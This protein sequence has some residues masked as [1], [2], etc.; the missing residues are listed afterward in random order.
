MSACIPRL[1][2][3]RELE[4]VGD[5]I[6]ILVNDSN[7]AV[8]GGPYNIAIPSHWDPDYVLMVELHLDLVACHLFDRRLWISPI[9]VAPDDNVIVPGSV[10]QIIFI[11]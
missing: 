5:R 8:V 6:D 3:S 10:V 11:Y 9:G 7:S 1:V 2:E 4:R